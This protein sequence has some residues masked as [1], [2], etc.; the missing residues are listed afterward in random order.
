[1]TTSL[2]WPRPVRILHWLS[3]ALVIGCLLAV[4][5][6]EFYP[7]GNPTRTMLMQLH[8]L[9]GGLIGLLVLVRIGVRMSASA[10]KHPMPSWM[11]KMASLAHVALYA[12]LVALPVAGYVAV[13]GKGA[14]LDILG[15]FEMPPLPVS[16]ELAGF[17]KESHEVL[18]N[19]L[20]F[21]L[22]LHIGAAAMHARMLGDKVLA[23]MLGRADD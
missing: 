20:V 17:A 5:G 9:A 14:P 8:F 21:M 6:H 2:N 13:S 3:A 4:W 12:S 11:A 15:L 7:K 1:M 23:G 10:P 16:K 19:L 22:F 18:G